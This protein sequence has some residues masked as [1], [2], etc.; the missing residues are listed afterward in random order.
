MNP[1][2]ALAGARRTIDA[3]QAEIARLKEAVVTSERFRSEDAADHIDDF[4]ATVKAKDAKIQR[5]QAALDEHRAAAQD[6]PC[7]TC[8]FAGAPYTPEIGTAKS[9]HCHLPLV[10]DFVPLIINGRPFGCRGWQA[11][12]AAK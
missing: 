11:K 2:E 4:A 6:G 3:L 9:R 1:Y 12:E 7:E 8:R 5:L 10:D